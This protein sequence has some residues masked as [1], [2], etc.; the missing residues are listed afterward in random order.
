MAQALVDV[1]DDPALAARLGQSA[2]QLVNQ[3]F[4][5]DAAAAQ[6]EA[7]YQSVRAVPA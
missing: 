7:V 6:L 5:W 4:D 2:R 1:M 3:R